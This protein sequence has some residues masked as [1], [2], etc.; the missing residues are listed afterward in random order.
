MAATTR[1]DDDGMISGINV[2]PLVDV[3]LVLLIV[4]L[5]TAK[6]V[7]SPALPVQVPE[8]KNTTAVESP[9]SVELGADGRVMAGGAPVT[10]D[11]AIVALAQTAK[12]ADPEAK[13]ILR[14]D[15]AVPHARVI[16]AIDLLKQGGIKH[17][18]FSVAPGPGAPL[19]APAAVP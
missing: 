8:A 12:A 14:V 1:S 19:V 16:R 2:T 18:A 11:A 9:L 6:L 5:V 7:V 10:N 3:A 15:G 13:A 4:F 17:V